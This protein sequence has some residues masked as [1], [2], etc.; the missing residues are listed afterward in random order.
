M[1]WIFGL[2][3]LKSHSHYKH[4]KSYVLV[5]PAYADL[6]EGKDIQ[7]DKDLVS[8]MQS[9]MLIRDKLRITK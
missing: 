2:E 7:S 3:K 1:V 4:D 9:V 6:S 8:Y 5:C